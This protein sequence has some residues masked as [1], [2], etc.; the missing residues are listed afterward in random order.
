VGKK[1]RR[2]QRKSPG[3]KTDSKAFPLLLLAGLG[4]FDKVKRNCKIRT[5]N[6]YRETQCKAVG[7]RQAEKVEELWGKE[8]LA[9]WLPVAV[10]KAN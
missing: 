9:A 3:D 7:L 4:I 10:S 2:G 5:G 8:D 1:Q 6:L